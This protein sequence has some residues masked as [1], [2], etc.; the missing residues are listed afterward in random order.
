[1]KV[2]LYKKIYF[3]V[4]ICFSYC[5][6]AQ[7]TVLAR[8]ESASNYMSLAVDKN[9][10]PFVLYNDGNSFTT[11]KKYENNT[12][13]SVGA[14]G[15]SNN[16]VFSPV[17]AISNNDSVY[18]AFSEWGD[19]YPQQI[20]VMKFNGTAW[21]YV[22]N[23]FI[24]PGASNF[25]S[26][27]TDSSNAPFIAFQDESDLN[28]LSVMKFNGKAWEYVGRRSFSPRNASYVSLA[29]DKLNKPYVAFRDSSNKASVM[30]FD[31]A[32]WSV[33]GAFG[34]SAGNIYYKTSLAFD[35][36][37]IP[38][39]AYTD[40]ANGNKATVMKFDGIHWINAGPPGFSPTVAFDIQI[41][42]DSSDAAYVGYKNNQFDGKATV[43]KL[44]NNTWSVV[45]AEAF[46]PYV[47]A[48]HSLALNKYGTPYV[49]TDSG[50]VTVMKYVNPPYRFIGNGDWNNAANWSNNVIPPNPLPGDNS[51]II[52]PQGECILNDTI[53][54]SEGA[55]LTVTPGK[56]FTVKG[57]V[58]VH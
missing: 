27:A 28:K 22:G 52:D 54:L 24:T 19:G 55:N 21:V 26:L 53:T 6:H 30:K 2:N 15:F 9:N 45:G 38:Y 1:M 25:V 51:I 35:N 47:F 41:A 42:I 39:V 11:V 40:V 36:N 31:G 12:W 43:M 3:F 46:T 48:N 13:K 7:W 20:S 4:T 44:G 58:L 18:T 8:I 17:L 32:D 33:V 49:A 29:F 14:R 23:R 56:K 5:A 10:V 57:N 34:F 37:N 50:S 16:Y